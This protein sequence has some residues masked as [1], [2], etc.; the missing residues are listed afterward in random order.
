MKTLHERMRWLRLTVV[1][2][3]IVAA[4]ALVIVLMPGQIG[5]PGS[6]R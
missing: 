3:F 5:G 1:A 4:I 6:P 2:L